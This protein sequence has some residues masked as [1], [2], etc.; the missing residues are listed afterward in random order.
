MSALQVEERPV[1][2]EQGNPIRLPASLGQ[3][4]IVA[5]HVG[6]G[7][8]VWR[9]KP[10]L[11]IKAGTAE[12]TIN[13]SAD[14][15]LTSI[16]ARLNEYVAQGATVGYFLPEPVKRATPI[17]AP[18]HTSP[19][20]KTQP[21]PSGEALAPSAPEPAIAAVMEPA[22]K[23]KRQQRQRTRHA[24]WHV[25]DEQADRLKKT[26]AQLT[27]QNISANESELVRA[28]LEMFFA[29]PE[30]AR[31]AMI[32]ENKEREMAGRYGVG[33]PKPGRGRGK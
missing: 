10:V 18:Q 17:A 28:A 5:W 16:T 24:T 2:Q 31:Q 13:A 11:T 22:P 23:P 12:R 30:P 19:A 20:P 27:L 21:A 4:K 14:G 9:G 6:A 26:V 25:T 29:L 33:W 3:C 15:T 32:R 8:W 7:E 1:A